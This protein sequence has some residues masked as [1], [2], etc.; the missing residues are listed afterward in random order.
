MFFHIL[1]FSSWLVRVGFYIRTLIVSY[2]IIEILKHCV[3]YIMFCV[4]LKFMC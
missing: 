4:H 1:P 2:S 3:K